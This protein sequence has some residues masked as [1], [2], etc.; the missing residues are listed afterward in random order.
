[1]K[2]LIDKCIKKCLNQKHYLVEYFEQLKEDISKIN[3]F[4]VYDGERTL[5]SMVSD[6]E[7]ADYVIKLGANIYAPAFRENTGYSD[8]PGGV[9]WIHYICMC[10]H[11]S[12][13]KHIVEKY[14][15][16]V[17]IQNK[18]GNTLLHY[19]LMN[20]FHRAEFARNLSVAKYLIS[21]GAN[22]NILNKNFQSAMCS[23]QVDLRQE[24]YQE[25]MN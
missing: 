9:P 1:M 22:V 20:S 19:A 8:I 25:L 11:T 12:L 18:N 6:I 16:D 2:K 13:V 7:L 5:L 10:K 3:D 4:I 23:M 15:V 17:N 21:K 14:N 24:A